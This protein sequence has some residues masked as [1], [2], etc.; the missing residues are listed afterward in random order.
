MSS[1]VA[2]Q[3]YEDLQALEYEG[4]QH[5]LFAWQIGCLFGLL[6][7]FLWSGFSVVLAENLT[8]RWGADLW[9]WVN[10]AY[11]ALVVLGISVFLFPFSYYGGYVLEHHYGLSNQTVGDWSGDYLKSVLMDLVI[12]SVLVSV[13]YAFLRW[14]PEIWWWVGTGFYIAFSLLFSFLAPVV[15]LPLFNPFEP[16]EDGALEKRVRSV[17]ASAGITISGVYCWG[18]E[19]K[20]N[21]AN[22]A[23]VGVG[24]TKRIILSDTLLKAYSDEEILA[25]VAHEAGHCRNRDMMRLMGVHAGFALAG[26]YVVD[27]FLHGLIRWVGLSSISDIAGAPLFFFGVILFSMCMMPVANG[28]SRRREF[29]ADAYAVEAMGSAEALVSALE[30][31]SRQNLSVR[32][33][34]R[35]VE[36]FLH[37]HPSL[38]RRV[39]RARLRA[40]ELA[41]G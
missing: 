3:E 1:E 40:A 16:L 20:T 12:A 8:I 38:K 29:A 24:K 17:V 30:K 34:K 2:E 9:F 27:L 5:R 11:T 10:M 35:W 37:S 6:I 13:L 4:A 39:E 23:F 31:L 15:I 33:P 18:V 28:Y 32:E 19:E 25:V 7:A 26:F 41:S 22:A 36:W 21:T 14:I